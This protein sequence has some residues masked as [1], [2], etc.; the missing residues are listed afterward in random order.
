MFLYCYFGVLATE[1]FKSMTDSL[2][3]S[4][5]SKFPVAL[6]KYVIVM[7]ANMQ[8]PLRY[9][10]FGIANLDLVTFI[11]VRIIQS[12]QFCKIKQKYVFF[13]LFQL[14]RS[15]ITYYMMFKTIISK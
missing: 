1:S 2:Y 15:V 8:K 14:I 12:I 6:Q 7:I 3:E 4:E 9:H 13:H 5:W 10:G 11:G